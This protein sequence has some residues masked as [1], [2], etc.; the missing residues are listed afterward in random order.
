MA[1]ERQDY[2]AMLVR[3]HSHFVHVPQRRLVS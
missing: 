1:M 3:G 2:P